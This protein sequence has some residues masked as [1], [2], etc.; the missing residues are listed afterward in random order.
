MTPDDVREQ[1]PYVA[2]HRITP[3][4]AARM[5]GKGRRQIMGEI[6]DRTRRPPMGER[7]R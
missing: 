4:A 3:N 1:F 5:E 6:A 2:A 7:R